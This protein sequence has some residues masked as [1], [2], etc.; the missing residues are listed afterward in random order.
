MFNRGR[1][2][3][4]GLVLRAVCG[5]AGVVAGDI[6]REGDGGTP[7][8]LL[9]LKRVLYRPDRFNGRPR[10]TV[11]MK[12]LA[13][14]DAWCDD[15]RHPDYNMMVKL[16]FAGR[17]ESLWRDDEVYDLIG[18]LDWNLGPIT[19]GRGSAI[20]FHIATPAFAPTEGCIA[21]SRADALAAL[22]AGMDAINVVGD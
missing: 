18:V 3:G 4:E 10:G 8:G 22:A 7:K 5:R 13:A 1:L 19:P 17:Y 9:R 11:P 21:V 6:K 20:F 2:A 16:P 12:A 14:D 15:P